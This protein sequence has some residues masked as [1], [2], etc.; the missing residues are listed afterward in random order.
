VPGITS[1][2]RNVPAKYQLLGCH[3]SMRILI[4]IASF[5]LKEKG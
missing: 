4:Q 3:P 2:R 5:V 1:R